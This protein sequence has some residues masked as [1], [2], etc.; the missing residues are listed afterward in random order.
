MAIPCR[1]TFDVEQSAA[2]IRDHIESMR[3]TVYAS[4]RTIEGARQAMARADDVL[5]RQL[6]DAHDGCQGWAAITI[7]K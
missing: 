1:A 3:N 6:S 5:A 7:L 4:R 2:S